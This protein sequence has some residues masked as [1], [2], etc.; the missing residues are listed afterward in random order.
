MRLDCLVPSTNVSIHDPKYKPVFR[1]VGVHQKRQT[2]GGAGVAGIRIRITDMNAVAYPVWP[3]HQNKQQPFKILGAGRSDHFQ[4]VEFSGQ[5]NYSE[6]GE[7]YDLLKAKPRINPE[8]ETNSANGS[9]PM[10]LSTMM[11][12]MV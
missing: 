9:K 10:I 11:S 4:R 7:Q 2:Y 12:T 8:T 5:N 6:R 1:S 3:T